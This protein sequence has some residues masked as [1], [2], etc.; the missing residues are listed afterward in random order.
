LCQEKAGNP[1]LEREKNTV[2]RS[3]FTAL[4]YRTLNPGPATTCGLLPWKNH[5]GIIRFHCWENLNDPYN[6]CT[7]FGAQKAPRPQQ[8]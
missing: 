2:Q 3:L 7:H 6:V 4:L 5:G 1:G 8:Q